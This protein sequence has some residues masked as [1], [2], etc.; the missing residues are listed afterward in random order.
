ML[1]LVTASLLP[2]VSQQTLSAP[3]TS[4]GGTIPLIRVVEAP[5]SP[6]MEEMVLTTSPLVLEMTNSMEEMVMIL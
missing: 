4:V 3:L 1:F 2:S 5:A 6:S